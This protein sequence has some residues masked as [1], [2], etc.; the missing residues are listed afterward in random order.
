MS[1]G[2][3]QKFIADFLRVQSRWLCD[4]CIARLL[5]ITTG[6][7]CNFTCRMASAQR[8]FLRT[9]EECAECGERRTCTL[10]LTPSED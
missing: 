2:T 7:L 9:E 5:G 8:Y 6:R 3:R 4:Q 10:A 1:Q